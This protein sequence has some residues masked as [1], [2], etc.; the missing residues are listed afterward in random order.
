MLKLGMT[1]QIIIVCI[2]SEIIGIIGLIVS[3]NNIFKN[4]KLVNNDGVPYSKKFIP[5]LTA[6]TLIF[7]IF[8]SLI[9]G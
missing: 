3:K 2:V 1:K 7:S 9:L 5:L 8:C 6:P 4:V